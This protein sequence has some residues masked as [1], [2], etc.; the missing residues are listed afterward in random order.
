[1]D[2]VARFPYCRACTS[3]K[4]GTDLGV[5]WPPARAPPSPVLGPSKQRLGEVPVRKPER[6]SWRIG[7]LERRGC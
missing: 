6:A 2:S 3:Q 5:S 4:R 7:G 1:M